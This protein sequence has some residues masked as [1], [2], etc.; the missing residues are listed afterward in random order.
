MAAK[1]IITKEYMKDASIFADAFNYFLYDGK[2]VIDPLKL[3]AMDTTEISMPYREGNTQSPVQKF[4]DNLKYLTAMQDETAAYLV[5]GIEN[6]T[7]IHT[8]MPVKNMVY[9]ALK[10]AAQVE[11][12]AKSHRTAEKERAGLRKAGKQKEGSQAGPKGKE[13]LSGFYQ[14]DR[15]LPI[16][17]LVILFSPEPWDGPRCIH[18]MLSVKDEQILAFVPDYKINLIAPAHMDKEEMDKL[19]T[20]LR[21]VLLY[22]KYSK[23]KEKLQ[24][25]V[26]SDERFHYMERSAAVVINAITHSK[27]KFD[28]KEEVIDMC[29][30]IK[31][32]R[33]EA[34]L[35]GRS[36]G[37]EE[38]RK[39]GLE[40][41]ARRMLKLGKYTLEEIAIC[42][43]L[44][45]ERINELQNER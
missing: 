45:L 5:L 36:E 29:Q 14:Q 34:M 33:E 18:E 37:R 19:K 21:E 20:S 28:E 17:T 41:T 1:D 31:E 9:D 22:I 38:G 26:L 12:A 16:I 3:H 44:S 30:A 40:E 11:K 15:L 27:I 24:Q 8:A 23:D 42:S 25:V 10:Y 43:N 2:Q 4:R 32:M 35:I 13:Y 39:E 7:D 6:Q